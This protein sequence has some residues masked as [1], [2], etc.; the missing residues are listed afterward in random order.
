MPMGNLIS[1]P[2]SLQHH[3]RG[4]VSELQPPTVTRHVQMVYKVSL[5]CT[6]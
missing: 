5:E 2:W 4:G 1:G 6:F 3:R